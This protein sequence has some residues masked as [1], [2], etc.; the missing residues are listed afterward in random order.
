MVEET[1]TT[2]HALLRD[3]LLPLDDLTDSLVQ[4]FVMCH[5]FSLVVNV[6]NHDYGCVADFS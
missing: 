3:A 4:F 2:K 1:E 6:V 5:R